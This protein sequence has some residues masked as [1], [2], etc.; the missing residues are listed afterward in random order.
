MHNNSLIGGAEEEARRVGKRAW[1]LLIRRDHRVGVFPRA[2]PS[3][4]TRPHRV[5]KIAR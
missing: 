2:G 1:E 3:Q 5:G 4:I